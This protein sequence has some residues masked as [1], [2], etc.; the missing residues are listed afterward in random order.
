MAPRV[1]IGSLLF[2]VSLSACA[3]KSGVPDSVRS[4]TD[5]LY[6]ALQPDEATWEA[7][8]TR[9]SKLHSSFVNAPD[10]SASYREC[11]EGAG[12]QDREMARCE[13]AEAERLDAQIHELL[14]RGQ[15]TAAG[16]GR[17]EQAVWEAE[18]REGCAWLPSEEGT[19]GELNAASCVTNRLANR[20]AAL[21]A[22][23]SS[24]VGHD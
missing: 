22:N 2:A 13:Y 16:S 14:V 6:S 17:E 19:A 20:L 23:L 11:V 4:S 7:L 1:F 8:E 24:E 15:A 12:Q 3:S 10:R 5:R 21:Q 9:R 18:T